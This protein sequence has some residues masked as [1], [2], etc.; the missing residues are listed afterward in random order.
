VVFRDLTIVGCVVFGVLFGNAAMGQASI[1]DWAFH[2][3]GEAGETKTRV[4]TSLAHSY[5]GGEPTPQ[6]VIRQVK[7]GSPVELLIIDTHD[8]EK[9]KC[10]YKDWKI[11]IDAADVP[12]LGYT[13]E[14][15]KTELKPNWGTPED[16]LWGLFRK[17]F[18]LTA[19]VERKCDSFAGESRLESYSFSLRGSSAAYMFVTNGAE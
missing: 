4:A 5:A 11:L 14:P 7:A 19:Q 10:E 16:K 13:F 18:K 15:T 2:V 12:V 6:L 8:D 1:G 9:D 17:G 3:E